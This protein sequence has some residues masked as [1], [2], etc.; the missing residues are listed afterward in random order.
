MSVRLLIFPHRAR[1]FCYAEYD[2]ASA[3]DQIMVGAA[4]QL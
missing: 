2:C 4:Q 1:M 3:L